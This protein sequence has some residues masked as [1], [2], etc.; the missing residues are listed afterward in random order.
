MR[1]S[2]QAQ[3]CELCSTNN[4]KKLG[5]ARSGIVN[6]KGINRHPFPVPLHW[7]MNEAITPHPCLGWASTQLLDSAPSPERSVATFQLAAW[8][9]DTWE[10]GQ[11]AQTRSEGMWSKTL[12]VGLHKLFKYV[13]QEDSSL[14]PDRLLGRTATQI[15]LPCVWI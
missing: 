5:T 9:S 10:L 12:G 6:P 15:L 8:P 11:L 4:G 2:H 7:P 1:C 14:K 3:V 13:G